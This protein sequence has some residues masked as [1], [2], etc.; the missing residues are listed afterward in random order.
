MQEVTDDKKGK[1]GWTDLRKQ[2]WRLS[3][4]LKSEMLE[5]LLISKNL[6]FKLNNSNVC[7]NKAI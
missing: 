7:Q 4:I 2:K 6:W 1:N 5:K 3:S